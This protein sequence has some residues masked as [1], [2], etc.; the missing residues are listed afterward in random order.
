[1]IT[2]AR[3]SNEVSNNILR[4]FSK[5]N[6]H[7]AKKAYEENLLIARVLYKDMSKLPMYIKKRNKASKI[8]A[9]RILISQKRDKPQ[10]VL[11]KHFDKYL[12]RMKKI[13]EKFS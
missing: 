7:L 5:Q 13:R 9:D 1:M 10:S 12:E 2:R 4:R 3:F 8:L 11:E 6:P